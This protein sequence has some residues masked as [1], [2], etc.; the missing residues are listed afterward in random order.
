MWVSIQ[1]RVRVDRMKWMYSSTHGDREKFNKSQ[2]EMNK[3]CQVR[4]KENLDEYSPLNCLLLKSK[5]VLFYTKM[6]DILLY[7]RCFEF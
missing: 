4:L 6:F 7:L 3:L 2:F 5:R 1:V